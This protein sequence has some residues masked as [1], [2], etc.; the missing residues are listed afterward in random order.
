[1]TTPKYTHDC[2]KCQFLGI[3]HDHDLYVC[4]A[5]VI[6]GMGPS[7]IARFGNEGPEYLSVPWKI[8][9]EAPEF[10]SP[11]IR[12]AA[13]AVAG[14]LTDT[15]RV[16][17]EEFR[18]FLRNLASAKI[19]GEITRHANQILREELTSKWFPYDPAPFQALRAVAHMRDQTVVFGITA[20]EK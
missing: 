1:M 4:G 8:L 2:D 18:P 13:N 7:V 6:P 20:V 10:P 5:R 16:R 15:I 12:E 19:L 14:V 11:A 3:A 9:E 17:S